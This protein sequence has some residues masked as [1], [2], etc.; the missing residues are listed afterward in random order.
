VIPKA[1]GD[2]WVLMGAGKLT[3]PGDPVPNTSQW[4]A[5]IAVILLAADQDWRGSL[6]AGTADVSGT[7]LGATTPV[8]THFHRLESGT[9]RQSAVE[10]SIAPIF[11]DKRD[12]S[13]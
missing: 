3:P 1:V 7:R 10:F 4:F 12:G 5:A 13:H 9:V 8:G 6:G 2:I 11:R